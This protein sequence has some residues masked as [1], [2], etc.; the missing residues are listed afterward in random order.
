VLDDAMKQA[1]QTHLRELGVGVGAPPMHVG[2]GCGN[3]N[4]K[5]IAD[6]LD[7]GSPSLALAKALGYRF[8]PW[9][10]NIAAKFPDASTVD[11]PPAGSDVR[12]SQDTIVTDMILLVTN[13]NTAS[14]DFSY[15]SDFLGNWQNGLQ[16]TLAVDG[17]PGYAVARKFTPLSSLGKVVQGGGDAWP[18]GMWVLTTQQGLEMAFQST[19][20]LPVFPINVTCTFRCWIPQSEDFV[21][22]SR[23]TAIQ[24]LQDE[25]GIVLPDCYARRAASACR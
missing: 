25:C 2:F 8:H 21:N 18:G 23:Q 14:S 13:G 3:P 4:A 17:Q 5:S 15:L 11:V 10:I 24:R 9:A 20:P 12:I 1:I 19:V 6:F 16:A 22:M 7:A